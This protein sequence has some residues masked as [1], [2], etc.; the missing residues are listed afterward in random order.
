MVR[1]I[2]QVIQVRMNDVQPGDIVNKNA[3]ASV[4]W[5]LA[6]DVEELHTGDIVVVAEVEKD[7]INGAPYDLVGIQIAKQVQ[8]PPAA[9]A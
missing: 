6:K 9:A 5:F 2:V 4:G 1:T 8:A 3:D 7:S